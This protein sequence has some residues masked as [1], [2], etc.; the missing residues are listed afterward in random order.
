LIIEPKATTWIEDT[1]SR[2]RA[3]IRTSSGSFLFREGVALFQN[4]INLRYADG[5]AV[6]NLGGE[7]DAED[8][9]QKGLNYRTEPIWFRMGYLPET[10][11]NIT[12]SFDFSNV[13]SNSKVGG[14]PVTPIFTAN[15]GNAFR[16]RV[17]HPGGGHARNNVFTVHGHIWEEEPF[18]TGST[19][20]GANPLSEWNGAQ[21]GFGGAAHFNFLL[22]NGAGGKF[23]ISGD[24][25]YRTFQADQ[26]D[27]GIWGLFRV[28]SLFG[29]GESLDQ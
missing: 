4:D 12:R 28:I 18:T 13:L 10:P 3:T 25:L 24:Y 14:D 7:D 1:K 20:I 29:V 5:T 19:V 11:F 21:F 15:L 9:G 26:F 6:K 27:N 22:K 23:R 8:S 17:V 2:A 16:F